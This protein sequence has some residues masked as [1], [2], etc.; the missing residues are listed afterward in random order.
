MSQFLPQIHRQTLDVRGQPWTLAWS[1]DLHAAIHE[2]S[3][4]PQVLHD[5]LAL[6]GHGRWRTTIDVDGTLLA[7]AVH[8]DERRLTLGSPR[9]QVEQTLLHLLPDDPN[10]QTWR[11]H[12]AEWQDADPQNA[13]RLVDTVAAVTGLDA[14]MNRHAQAWP[15]LMAHV[16]QTATKVHAATEAHR[17]GLQERLSQSGLELCAQ[18]PILRVHL[19]RFVAALPSLDHDE[20]GTD[21]VRLLRETLRHM[22]RDSRRV[23]QNPT[24][25]GQNSLP[26]WVE[27]ACQLGNRLLTLVPVLWLATLTRQTVRRLARYFIAGETV[28]EAQVTLADLRQTGRDAT[29]DQLGELVVCE[30]EADT[31]CDRVLAL[32]DGVA[33]ASGALRNQADLPRAHVSVK[34]SALCS[35]FNPDDPEG[36]WKRTGPRLLKILRRAQELGAC[37]QLDAEHRSVRDLNLEMLKRALTESDLLTWRDVGIVVQAY[38]RDAPQHFA[39]VI[40]LAR[41][42]KLAMPVRLVKGAYW[43][44]E[45]TEALAHDFLPSQWLNK[46][47]TDA[48]FQLLTLR[49]LDA[50]DAVQLCVASHNLRDHVF[51]HEARAQLYPQ[52]PPLEHQ[53]LHQSYEGLSRALAA[54]GWAV[55]HYVPVGSLLVGMA[56]LVRRILENS[57]QVGVL[58]MARHG[59]DLPQLLQMPGD[60]LR[61]DLPTVDD[62]N[63]GNTQELAPFR[64][65]A[66]ARLYLPTHR[67]ALER[68]LDAPQN[69]A[70]RFPP[71]PFERHGP[72][73]GSPSPSQPQHIVGEIRHAVNEDVLPAVNRA[74]I[75][76]WLKWPVKHRSTLLMRTAERMRAQRMEVAALVCQEAG[77]ARAEA[78]ADVDEA[79]DFLNFYALEAL[80]LKPDSQPLGVVAVVSPWNFPLAIPTGMVA[81]ALAAGNAVILKS[82]EQTPLCAEYLV[83]LLHQ[84]GVPPDAIQHLPGDGFSVGGPLVA[85]PRVG[86]AIFTGSVPVGLGIWQRMLRKGHGHTLHRVI[87]EMGGKNAILV[88]ATADLDEA[89]SGCLQS[90]FGHAGQKCSAASRI[91][92]DSRI[93]PSFRQRFGQAAGELVLGRAEQPGTRVN[94]VIRPEEVQRLR[95]QAVEALAECRASGGRVLVD[96][97]EEAVGDA[98]VVGPVVLELPSVRIPQESLAHRELFGPIV[99]VIP[100]DRLDDALQ[101]ANNSPYALTGGV[102]AQSQDD[103]QQVL[104][105]LRAGNLYVN[106]PITGARVAVEP[107]GGFQL[108]GTGPKAG[109]EGYVQ[110]LT[111]KHA[112]LSPVDVQA[113]VVL[114]DQ[115]LHEEPAAEVRQ[116]HKMAQEVFVRQAE[117]LQTVGLPTRAIAGQ[118]N[119]NDWSIPRGPTLV[120]A[121]RTHPNAG[122]CAHV[123]AARQMNCPVHVLTLSDGAHAFWQQVPA[124]QLERVD[125]RPLLETVLNEPTWSTI[126]LDGSMSGFT[127]VIEFVAQVP[128]GSRDLRQI[129]VGAEEIPD[130]LALLQMHAHARTIAVHTMRHGAALVV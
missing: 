4:L 9:F 24:E 47:E 28:E 35:D 8:V 29:L 76:P 109:G 23:R 65:V 60:A 2:N 91:F 41:E 21:V 86:G 50:G 121:A 6:T 12:Y 118:E 13:P 112:A 43:D 90:V 57:S 67:A 74:L 3:R 79:I 25:S 32:L 77:K 113:A 33:Q 99:H 73:E 120:L 103:I 72:R 48:M 115:T 106:R 123:R 81:G 40:E 53:V 20:R 96:R 66:P 52:A 17:P 82:A 63:L 80:H 55:R 98:W 89:V 37:I 124:I 36:T 5:T 39:E 22:R 102:F 61:Q 64:N 45:T 114:N 54:Q 110:A 51:A 85:H 83:Q 88:T 117:M 125:N 71:P 27:L 75:S 30:S 92:V 11:D 93:L 18:Q 126:I 116:V 44:A 56:Y 49:A 100:Y 127:D 34:V 78:L 130:S 94:P 104:H 31:Y 62:L 122:T 59:A 10:L 58:T 1:A 97:S 87:T 84:V 69:L 70:S 26:L 16:H 129:I 15:L 111:A 105:Q 19:L 108:S 95:E 38:L 119:H 14:L 46:A 68:A 128:A 7:L 107:F 101:V 42:R